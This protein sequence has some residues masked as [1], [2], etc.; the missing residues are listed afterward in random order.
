M[1][2]VPWW[3]RL[4]TFAVVF[5]VTAWGVWELENV[6]YNRFQVGAYYSNGAVQGAPTVGLDVGYFRTAATQNSSEVTVSLD[7]QLNGY[8][9][10]VYQ[11]TDPVAVPWNI[12]RIPVGVPE[13]G[14]YQLT[15]SVGGQVLGSTIFT[16]RGDY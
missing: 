1:T 4:L 2:K 14:V 8:W 5:S 16:V 6:V 13:P 7:K 3:W 11:T 15:L 12:L 9:Y 10:T